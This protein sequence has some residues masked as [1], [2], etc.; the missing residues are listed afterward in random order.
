[1]AERMTTTVAGGF[2]L[3]EGPR[4]HNGALWFVD[5]R[6]GHVN[7]LADGVVERIATFDHPASLGFRGDDVLVADSHTQLLH[8]VRDGRVVESLDLGWLAKSHLNDMIVD[9][10]GRAYVDDTGS[11][12]R[13]EGWKS[14]GR[15]LLVL[16]DGTAR[17]V[18]EDILVPNGIAISPDGRTLVVGESLGPGGA[19]S[20]A[21]LFGFDVAKDGSLSNR[22]VMGTIARGSGDG[23][24]FDAEGAV[25]VGTAFGHEV[26][27]FLGG[28]VVDRIVL[29]DRKWALA[30]ALGGS[31][32]R[33]MFIC[34]A[35]PPPKGDPG[36]FPE[37]WV[38]TVEVEVPG[39]GG[40]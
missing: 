17:V 1:M 35:A 8:T 38:E 18:A 5:M 26:Q 21:H 28:E 32:M 34:T 14:N 16:P 39:V 29:A 12:F 3:P 23:L 27:R 22:R 24:C 36:A 37:G 10:E 13:T 11:D 31:D 4:W 30:C 40:P 33:T 25:W 15:V 19:P 7:R 9:S 6:R 2:L 20:G